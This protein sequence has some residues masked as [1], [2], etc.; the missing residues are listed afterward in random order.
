MIQQQKKNEQLKL[1]GK[2]PSNNCSNE[3]RYIPHRVLS[4]HETPRVDI[5]SSPEKKSDRKTA[6]RTGIPFND[7][8]ICIKRPMLE[9]RKSFHFHFAARQLAI[10]RNTGI[11]LYGRSFERCYS[12]SSF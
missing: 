2:G 12:V 4:S 3:P 5:A 7:L 8:G 11:K 6:T 10:K 1:C 9:G